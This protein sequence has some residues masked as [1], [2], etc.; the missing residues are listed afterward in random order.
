MTALSPTQAARVGAVLDL[1]DRGFAV[2]PLKPN[3]KV[4]AITDWENRATLDRSHAAEFWTTRP[5]HNIGVACGPSNL[6]V[7]DCDVAADGK[8]GPDGFNMIGI[9]DG[10][11]VLGE[12]A[13]RARGDLPA[14]YMVATPS[15]GLHLVYRQPAG[16]RL[17]STIGTLGWLLDTRGHGGYVVAAGS[18]LPNGG[19][20]LVDE[21]DPA[22]LPAWLVQALSPK[23]PT[24]TPG[25]NDKPVTN[26][27]RLLHAIVTGEQDK[28]RAAPSGRHNKTLFQAALTLGQLVAGGELDHAEAESLLQHAAQPLVTGAC[29]C[30]QAEVDATIRSG[31]KLGGSKARRLTPGRAA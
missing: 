24:A 21:A 30:T 3:S 9:D 10:L 8:V 26:P 22:E 6:L 15:G 31:L 19:Y 1:I 23:P 27:N 2:F 14:T 11:G 13:R 20:E 17:R 18:T 25:R 4:P 28:V 7:V 16:L 29:R 12:L 5:H